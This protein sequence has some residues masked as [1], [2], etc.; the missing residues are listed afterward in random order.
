MI[1]DRVTLKPVA[2]VRMVAALYLIFFAGDVS[3][4]VG[5]L[6]LLHDIDLELQ[7]EVV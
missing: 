5:V 6:F 3:T 1:L 4:F 2:F 7:Y